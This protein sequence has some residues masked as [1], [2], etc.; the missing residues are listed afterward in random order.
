MRSSV[1]E[2]L[3]PF[4]CAAQVGKA[5]SA[6]EVAKRTVIEGCAPVDLEIASP[7]DGRARGPWGN[8]HPPPVQ[9]CF[10]KCE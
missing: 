6:T 5:L 7:P 8:D 2:V 3:R 4:S 10:T 9:A 1:L